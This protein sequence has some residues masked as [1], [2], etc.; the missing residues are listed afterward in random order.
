MLLSAVMALSLSSLFN[1][2]VIN[3]DDVLMN[4]H[5][6]EASMSDLS[7]DVI[8]SIRTD[9]KKDINTASETLIE[10]KQHDHLAARKRLAE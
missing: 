3:H 8:N 1:E 4:K 7:S 10:K 5:V 9:I 6:I 2:P